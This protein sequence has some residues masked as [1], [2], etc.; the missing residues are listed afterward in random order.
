MPKV[1][2]LVTTANFAGAERYV[3]TSANEVAERG[4]ETAVVGGSPD[5][6]PEALHPDV[7]W[8]A[9]ANP[10]E[11]MRSLR[12]LGPQN[13]CHAHM[14]LAEA[15]AGAGARFHRAPIL[16]TR[17]FAAARGSS[18]A[19]RLLAPW[20]SAR[21]AR[22]IAIS[23]FVAKHLER[24]PD[25]VIRNGVPASEC[26]WRSTSRVV[27]VLQRLEPEKDTRT[28]LEAWRK[29]RLAESRWSLRVVGAGSQRE[30]LAAW[31]RSECIPGV[32]FADWTPDVSDEFGRA[33]I[34]LAPAPTE[35]FGLAV[36]E[37]MAAG[38]PVVAC[39]SGGHLET[40][41]LLPNGPMF[42]PGDADAA[43]R[44]LRS[45]QPDEARASMSS[46]G[47]TLVD[48]R[49]TIG[50][51]VDRL[52]AEYRTVLDRGDGARSRPARIPG[53]RSDDQFLRELV[54]CSLEAWDE[55]WRRNQFFTD[56]L[57]RRN[58]ALRVLFVE[59][60]ADPLFDLSSRRTPTPPRFRSVSDDGRL[61]AFRP[62]KPLPRR[63]GP[64]A[65]DIVRRQLILA[66]RFLG[67][68]RPTLWV[69]D[70]TYAPLIAG[71][72]W[73]SLYDVTD[74]WLLAPFA[75][76]ELD[77]LRRLDALALNDADEVVVCSHAL[78]ASRGATRPVSLIPNGVDVEHF[79]RPRPRPGDLP[80]APVAVYV[81]SLHDA[82]IDIELVAELARTLP[83]L[84]LVLVGPNSLRH[85]SQRLLDEHPNVLLLGPRPYADVPAYLQHADVVV[86][87]HR[88]SPFTE[89]LDPIKAYE[90][91]AV[92]TPTVATPVAGFREHSA[93]LNIVDREAFVALVAKVVSEPARFFR[94]TEPAGWEERAV[95]FERV[96]EQAAG[97][98]RD[99]RPST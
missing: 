17:H 85:D 76:R 47:R 35:P 28:A 97:R 45:L 38:V 86:V 20:I 74:D 1:V 27:L 9:G 32:V 54:V 65:D 91:L 90:C 33:G 31:T 60:P 75:P 78:S 68:S 4:W 19:G 93:E 48:E 58:P 66:A 37:A 89:S 61:R 88:V 10:F 71:T 18:L 7:V 77:R 5:H 40:V 14:T 56:S 22:E 73:P 11:A 49:F 98:R 6:M 42:P 81:G 82:R 50:R 70:V 92:A 57:L 67:F 80:E 84:N 3:C 46:A 51:H 34:L 43:A 87:P 63:A 41:G 26:L 64:L 23:D 69:N 13:I 94:E 25:S 29:S 72:G 79:R 53:F 39:A 2:H 99:G 8:L 16:S 30:P 15:V 24:P 95:A 55:V 52:L 62:L 44:A 12:Q 36:V 83:Q 59:P 96:L 21:L